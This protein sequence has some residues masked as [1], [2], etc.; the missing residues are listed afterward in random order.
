MASKFRITTIPI[1][2]KT[3]E[4]CQCGLTKRVGK[5]CQFCGRDGIVSKPAPVR[6]RYTL[7]EADEITKI[8]RGDHYMER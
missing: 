3:H 5:E 6:N 4:V 1:A 7:V 8:P 2:V